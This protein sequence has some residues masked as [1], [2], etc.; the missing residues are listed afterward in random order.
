M[1]ADQQSQVLVAE[2]ILTELFTELLMHIANDRV[3]FNWRGKQLRRWLGDRL[4][5]RYIMTLP[6]AKL[7]RAECENA[8][9]N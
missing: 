7:Y 5:Q 3:P 2:E 4:T 6:E 8:M 1:R 9:L